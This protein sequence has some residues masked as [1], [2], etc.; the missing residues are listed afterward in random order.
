MVKQCLHITPKSDHI[1]K[2]LKLVSAGFLYI[3]VEIISG[4]LHH[5][6]GP[7][8]SGKHMFYLHN[9]IGAQKFH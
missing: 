9:V 2:A 6:I 7:E 3:F 5:C 1:Y 4:N 8:F